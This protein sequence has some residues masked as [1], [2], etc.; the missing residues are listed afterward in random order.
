LIFGD[1]VERWDEVRD[2]VRVHTSRHSYEAGHLLI[3]AGAWTKGLLGL[4]DGPLTPKRVPVHWVVVPPDKG[5]QLGRFPVNFWQVPADTRPGTLQTYR[6]FY[7]LPATDQASR[8]KVAFHNELVDCDPE[9]LDRA[10]LPQEVEKMKGMI[11]QFLPALDGCPISSEVCLYTLTPDGHFY[12]GRRPGSDHVFGVALAGHGFKFAPALG[13]I[14]ADLLTG[15]APA[16]DV[17][18]FSPQRFEKT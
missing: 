15:N 3:A 11:A 1:R 7:S 4:P 14:L 8:I 6:E 18:V 5:M 2:H 16:F 9:K 13:E 10:V 12:I 17:G